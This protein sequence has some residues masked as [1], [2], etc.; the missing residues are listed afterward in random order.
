LSKDSFHYP[1]LLSFS[2]YPF[3][4]LITQTSGLLKSLGELLT[5]MALLAEFQSAV[6]STALENR[7]S[8]LSFFK[9]DQDSKVDQNSSALTQSAII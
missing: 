2:K 1:L 6:F 3:F 9:M 4:K 7:Q 8:S 5:R